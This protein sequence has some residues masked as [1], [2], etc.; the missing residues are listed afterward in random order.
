MRITGSNEIPGPLVTLPRMDKSP[1]H[2]PHRSRE[3]TILEGTPEPQQAH[4]AVARR[5]TGIRL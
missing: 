5:P 1:I 3:P 4:S 2:H